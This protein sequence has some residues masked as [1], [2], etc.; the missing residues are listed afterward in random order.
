MARLLFLGLLFA[1]LSVHGQVGCAGSSDEHEKGGGAQRAQVG[2]GI[3]SKSS[4]RRRREAIRQ[5]W[6][7]LE[8]VT[9]GAMVARFFIATP[10]KEKRR[11][12]LLREMEEHRDIV[13]VPCQESYSSL[14]LQTLAMLSFFSLNVSVPWIVKTDDDV[15][16]R[17]NS[18]LLHLQAVA[19]MYPPRS[20]VY[21]GWIV[22]GAKVHRNGKW[23]VSKRQHAAD[24]YPAYASGPT[25]ALTLPLARRI[26]GMNKKLLEEGGEEEM[27]RSVHLEDIATALS[28]DQLSRSMKVHLHDDRKF[29]KGRFCEPWALSILL[30][31]GRPLL[32]QDQD[33]LQAMLA[34][35]ASERESSLNATTSPSAPAAPLEA[36]EFFCPPGT[37]RS[38]VE[39]RI[40]CSSSLGNPREVKDCAPWL[41]SA[42]EAR[43]GRGRAHP[44]KF[45]ENLFP[46]GGERTQRSAEE[47]LLREG[48]R[49]REDW[50][51]H[52]RSRAAARA[53]NLSEVV[54]VGFAD[55]VEMYHPHLSVL[56]PQACDVPCVFLAPRAT[57]DAHTLAE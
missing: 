27:A 19:S 43:R 17:A 53:A 30:E 12:R 40:A 54:R 28:V 4:H 10:S 18:L 41:H 13:L 9:R 1:A 46:G 36:D 38:D 3:L 8:G 26:V 25:Y 15:F 22:R 55:D 29:H 50:V 42:R 52:V 57:S 31:G 23:A 51:A 5:S 49:A 24:V 47:A 34:L 11:K 39:G 48:R 37:L 21:A 35:S 7:Q 33:L 56:G 20:R 44:P 2:I 14:P 45:W 32:F 16:I 6:F